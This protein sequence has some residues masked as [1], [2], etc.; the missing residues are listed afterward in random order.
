LSEKKTEEN[1]KN[2]EQ[3]PFNPV[4]PGLPVTKIDN[5]LAG[6]N[7]NPFERHIGAMNLFLFPVDEDFPPAVKTVVINQEFSGIKIRPEP[8]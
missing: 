1:S 4:S 5:P 8:Q 6:R 2:R 7:P 3:R